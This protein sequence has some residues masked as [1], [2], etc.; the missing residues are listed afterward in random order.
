MLIFSAPV[1]GGV[2]VLE[3]GVTLPE[4]TTV[5]VIAA[6]T[7]APFELTAAE[8]AELAESVA[9]AERGDVITAAELF[10]RLAR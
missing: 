2:I 9:E 7:E 5:T 1:R 6:D 8:E 10:R 4:G 3:D